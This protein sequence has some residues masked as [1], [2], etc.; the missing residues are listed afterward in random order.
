M[1]EISDINLLVFDMDG[2]IIPSTKP[3]HEAIKRAFAKANLL[4]S[5]TEKEVKNS[6]G[7]PS[8]DF[9]RAIT[10]KDSKMSWQ[11]TR[12]IVLAEYVDALHDFAAAYPGVKETLETLR[13]RV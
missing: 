8:D 10:P 3:V 7:A 13:K 12:L 4:L 6:L 11:D 2:T 9:Y 1:I 5:V